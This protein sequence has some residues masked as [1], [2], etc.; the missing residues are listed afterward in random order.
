MRTKVSVL[1]RPGSFWKK[2]SRKAFLTPVDQSLYVL[3]QL[4]VN[5]ELGKR[6]LSFLK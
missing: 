3:I 5:K 4:F 6:R 2:G 1:K